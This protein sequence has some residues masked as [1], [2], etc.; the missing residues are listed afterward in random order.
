MW[1]LIPIAAAGV[2]WIGKDFFDWATEPDPAPAGSAG[3]YPLQL[4][5]PGVGGVVNL[6]MLGL[7]AYGGYKVYKAIK[8]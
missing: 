8:S 7:A 6:A 1:F 2:S 5:S 3:Q 4:I